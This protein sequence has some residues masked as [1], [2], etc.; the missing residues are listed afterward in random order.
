METVMDFSE[1]TNTPAQGLTRKERYRIK[2]DAQLA[3]R[4]K[5]KEAAEGSVNAPSK[6]LGKIAK[7]ATSAE[8]TSSNV[9]IPGNKKRKGEATADDGQAAQASLMKRKKKS[10]KAS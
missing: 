10:L 7:A 9:K 4:K 2:R 6:R 3:E 8:D 5:A 1:P